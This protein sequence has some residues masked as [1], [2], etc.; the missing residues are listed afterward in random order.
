MATRTLD[1]FYK[2][3]LTSSMGNDLQSKDLHLPQHSTR[4]HKLLAASMT[5]V[6]MSYDVY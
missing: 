6:N 3:C 4:A 2:G 1:A 5:T